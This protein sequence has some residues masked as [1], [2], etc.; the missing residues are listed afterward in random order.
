MPPWV[1]MATPKLL[2]V[3]ASDDGDEPCSVTKM[4]R[5]LP[6]IAPLL[7]VTVACAPGWA[8]LP[9]ARPADERL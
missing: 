7:A 1:L 3:S 8:K 4:P 9:T 6:V 5:L 2:P